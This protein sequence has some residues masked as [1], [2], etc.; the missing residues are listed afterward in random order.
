M[1]NLRPTMDYIEY[2]PLKLPN[3]PL[4]DILCLDGLKHKYKLGKYSNNTLICIRCDKQ[5]NKNSKN[6]EQNIEEYRHM[7]DF[8]LYFQN[9]CP[10]DNKFHEYKIEK[11]GLEKNKC[12]KC[13]YDK[14]FIEILELIKSEHHVEFLKYFKKWKHKYKVIKIKNIVPLFDNVYI[15][16]K[17]KKVDWGYQ[18][19][20][21][22]QITKM[23][24]VKY[25]Q[26]LNLGLSE[27]YIYDKIING[28][29]NPSNNDLSN[30]IKIN[31]LN[32]LIGYATYIIGKYNTIK[33]QNTKMLKKWFINMEFKNVNKMPVIMTNF[34]SELNG[35]VD[36]DKKIN[37]VLNKICLSLITIKKSNNK[38]WNSSY[39]FEYLYKNIIYFEKMKSIVK[40]SD[41]IGVQTKYRVEFDFGENT[42]LDDNL[43][44]RDDDVD[45]D[46]EINDPFSLD[47]IGIETANTG[48]DDEDFLDD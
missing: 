22:H 30:D 24:N 23:T 4:N 36:L 40:E 14:N 37:Y 2:E 28:S 11:D 1:R 33:S 20:N 12:F 48:A 8:I 10:K 43:L 16:M 3:I 32:N 26:W 6:I 29:E 46:K 13:N 34:H 41:D 5:F 45:L 19:D 27:N 35:I 47:A 21:I 31:R 7:R 17:T 38:D 42:M 9:T 44:D 39:L 15:P 18:I 25:N